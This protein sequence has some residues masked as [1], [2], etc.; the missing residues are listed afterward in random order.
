[1]KI[2]IFEVESW[3]REAF[4]ELSAKH[5]FEF[6]ENSLTEENVSQYVAADI[7]STFIYSEV[8]TQVLEQFNQLKLIATRST[9]FDYID[10]NYCHRNGITV[11]NVPTYGERTG[12]EHVFA[13]LLAI[14]HNIV[15]GIER[16][17]KGNFSIQFTKLNLELISPWSQVRIPPLPLLLFKTI[18]AYT[19]ANATM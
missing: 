17:R 16:T 8:T 6:L 7:I 18:I 9:C 11:S 1:M 12:A 4:K 13:V 19:S 10:I 14:S 2:I 3:E 15:E 5:D